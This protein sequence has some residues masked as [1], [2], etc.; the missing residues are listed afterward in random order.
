MVTIR[1]RKLGSGEFYYLEHTIK[2]G[3]RVQKKERYLGKE[4]P[5]NVDEIKKEFM[6]EIY[7]EKWHSKLDKIKKSFKKEFTHLPPEIREKYI[8]TFMIKFTYDTNRIEGGSLTHKEV[9][10]LLH[11]KITPA[12]K[13]VEDI[14]EAESHKKL[15]YLML[16]HNGELNLKTILEWHKILFADTKPNIAGKI[17]TYDVGIRG[18]D[19]LLP[20]WKFVEPLLKDFISW[21]DSNKNK[22]HPVELAAMVHLK[23]VRIHPFGDGNGRISRMLMNFILHKNGFPMLDISYKNRSSYYTAL[24]RSGQKQDDLIFIRHIISRYMKDYKKFIKK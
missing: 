5:K 12:H 22:L 15:F 21:Y 2:V 9:A 10:E 4:I 19:A 16:E 1:K 23:F 14:K 6:N 18:S 13:P 7:K 11:D 8:E 17:R 20:P 3:G 24:E